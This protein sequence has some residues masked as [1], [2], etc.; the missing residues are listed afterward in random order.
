M[1]RLLMPVLIA[2]SILTSAGLKVR[3]DDEPSFDV[4]LHGYGS[5]EFGQIVRGHGPQDN[6]Y[7]KVW[8]PKLYANVKL[9][10]TIQERFHMIIGPEVKMYG[11]FPQNETDP[12]RFDLK[13]SYDIYLDECYFNGHFGN[14]DQPFLSISLGYFKYKYNPHVRSLGEYMFR[15]GTYKP[16]IYNVFDHAYE[17]LL[18]ARVNSTLFDGLWQQDLIINSH[19]HYF[20][21]DD[22]SLSYITSVNLFKGLAIGAGINFDRLWPVDKKITTPE[23]PANMYVTGAH[24]YDSITPFNDTITVTTYDDTSYYSFKGV[25]L[26]G[27][28]SFDPKILF[29]DVSIFGPEDLVIYSEAAI[30]G[31]KNIIND[32]VDTSILK[33]PYEDITQRIPF[34]VGFNIPTFNV[35]DFLSV[36]IQHWE[37]PF[38][39]EFYRVRRNFIPQHYNA[40]GWDPRPNVKTKWS[41]FLQKSFL[42]QFAVIVAFARDNTFDLDET[43]YEPNVDF[44]ETYRYWDDW[45]W[46]VKLVGT[47]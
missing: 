44:E 9:D 2:L 28:I 41:I 26:M 38:A 13:Y 45:Y 47:F 46:R 22:Y 34:M 23:Y 3:A 25:K 11:K 18:G 33:H 30:I 5:Y 1:I 35:L 10:M 24:T 36:E 37:T 20:P 12:G 40:S 15:G 21:R 4:T 27:R 39:N 17:R 43:D 6:K 16:Y 31:V 7:T 19:T 8:R 14:L 29:P 42:D 32:D